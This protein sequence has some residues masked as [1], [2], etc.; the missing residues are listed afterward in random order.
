MGTP[1][2]EVRPARPRSRRVAGT[3]EFYPNLRARN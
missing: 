1:G 2:Q 3:L